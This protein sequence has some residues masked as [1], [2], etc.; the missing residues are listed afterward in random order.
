MKSKKEISE[1]MQEMFK[2]LEGLTTD[3]ALVISTV[4]TASQ[5][6]LVMVLVD[7]RDTLVDIK[8][9]LKYMRR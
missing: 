9:D 5:L 6:Y 4:N 7:I 8:K 1:Q 3:G 2:S